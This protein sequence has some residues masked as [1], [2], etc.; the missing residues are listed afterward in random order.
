LVNELCVY[1]NARCNY[2]KN[3]NNSLR[4]VDLKPTLQKT[5]LYKFCSEFNVAPWQ[6]YLCVSTV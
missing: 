2:K 3:D 4:S 5:G 6:K 1:Q